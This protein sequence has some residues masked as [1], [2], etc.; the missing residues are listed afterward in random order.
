MQTGAASARRRKNEHFLWTGLSSLGF[1]SLCNVV[2]KRI[3]HEPGSEAEAGDEGLQLGFSQELGIG[4]AETEEEVLVLAV[5]SFEQFFFQA[6]HCVGS[7]FHGAVGAIS[8]ALRVILPQYSVSIM[9]FIILIF[10]KTNDIRF[11]VCGACRRMQ[12]DRLAWIRYYTNK[13]PC[14]SCRAADDFIRRMKSLL[15][16]FIEFSYNAFSFK[17]LEKPVRWLK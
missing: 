7:P 4:V 12:A 16:D 3:H 10:H 15:I 8:T 1:L 11:M 14:I 2:H 5:Q 17:K 6:G 9:F 13:F